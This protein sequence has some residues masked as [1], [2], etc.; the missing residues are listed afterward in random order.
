[1]KSCGFSFVYFI[2][3]KELVSKSGTQNK[4]RQDTSKH[5]RSASGEYTINNGYRE[6]LGMTHSRVNPP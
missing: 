6:L 3:S 5:K 1:M 4:I 2:V